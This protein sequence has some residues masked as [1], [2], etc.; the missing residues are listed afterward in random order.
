[1]K[2]YFIKC[3]L[4]VLLSGCAAFGTKTLYK[5]SEIFNVHKIGY[6]DLGNTE[7]LIKKYP[8]TLEIFHQTVVSSFHECGID[9][10]HLI[11]SLRSPLNYESPDSI[12]IINACS[13]AGV[14]A[15]LI[16]QLSF[17][18]VLKD[19]E[20]KMKLYDKSGKLIISTSHNT[21]DGNSYAMPPPAKRL[22]H[23]GVAGAL[24]PICNSL[25]LK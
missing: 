7:N 20:A 25:A 23:D 6:I 5:S 8:N 10:V 19:T 24:K 21:M 12:M 3:I 16:S 13:Q 22:V 4:L 2:N 1:M 9:S 14:D 17:I 18:S 11:N 15:I